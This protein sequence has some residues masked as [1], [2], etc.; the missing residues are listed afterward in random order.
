MIDFYKGPVYE[1]RVTTGE[2][3]VPRVVDSAPRIIPNESPSAGAGSASLTLTTILDTA[4]GL[5][6]K[7][8]ELVVEAT[9]WLSIVSPP[10]HKHVAQQLQQLIEEIREVRRVRR[11]AS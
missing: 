11:V 9:D 5:T 7:A 2:I 10:V 6:L 8:H 3:E 4:E 1:G